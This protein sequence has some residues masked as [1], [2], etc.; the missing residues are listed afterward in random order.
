MRGWLDVTHWRRTVQRLQARWKYRTRKGPCVHCGQ[1]GDGCSPT[2]IL[3]DGCL[4]LAYVEMLKGEIPEWGDGRCYGC[5]RAEHAGHAEG[6]GM[7]DALRR[8]WSGERVGVEAE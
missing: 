2:S 6:C 4:Q 1:A 3:C 8:Y 5:G 7:D